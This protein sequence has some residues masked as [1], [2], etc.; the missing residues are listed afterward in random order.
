M[1]VRHPPVR[2][3][4]ELF[5]I[6]TVQSVDA[7]PSGKGLVQQPIDFSDGSAICLTIPATYSIRSLHTTSDI[8][9]VSD[10]KYEMDWL[11]RYEHGEFF[12][13]DG[14][15][16]DENLRYSTRLGRPVYGGGGIMRTYSYHRDTTGTLLLSD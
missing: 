10:A 16:L 8:R 15:K 4:Q 5:R 13:K 7:V 1:K 2:S 12:S 6:M 14:I 3:L 9:M 11:T